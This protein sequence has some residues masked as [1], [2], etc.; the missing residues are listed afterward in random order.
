MCVTLCT[1]GVVFPT[2]AHGQL[3]CAVYHAAERYALGL[4]LKA[5]FNGPCR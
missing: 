4:W 2:M 5:W 1:A 3:L